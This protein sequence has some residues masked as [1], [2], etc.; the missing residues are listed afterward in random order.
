MQAWLDSYL[1]YL[2]S[3]RRVS[4]HTVKGYTEDLVQ[5]C[6]FAEGRGR[7]CWMEVT[8][9][10]LR[11]FLAE[12]MEGG[13]A[14]ASVGRKLSSLRGIFAFL[15][16]R[17][18]REDN[19]TVGL[20]APKLPVRLPHYLE[21]DEITELLAEPDLTTPAGL[22]DRAI[23]ETLYATGTRVAELVSLN[24]GDISRADAAGGLAALRVTGKG[25][26]QRIVML[27]EEAIAAVQDYLNG[28]R[29]ALRTNAEGADDG[30]L[31]L[32]RHGTRLTARSV[33]RMLH[34]YVMRTCA[35]HGISPHALRHT[36]ATHLVNHGADL[37]TV[38]QLL[39]HVSL[40]TTEVYTHVSARR[41]REV[42]EKAHPRA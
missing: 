17:R 35:R 21:E 3:V 40:A 22:R 10:D 14:R 20:R 5:F 13:A 19:P 26:K 38:Q 41:L 24:V 30:S 34:K 2:T 31:F 8:T 15:N 12:L 4:L 1:E 42:Y 25:N 7:T 32:N 6:R 37:R 33:A 9:M 11:R 36:F 27:G 16:A 23:L 28:G 18:L 29:P 39:G